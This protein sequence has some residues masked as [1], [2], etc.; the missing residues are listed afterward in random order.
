MASRMS[1]ARI[2]EDMHNRSSDTLVLVSARRSLP[3]ARRLDA[4]LMRS[5]V[6]AICLTALVGCAEIHLESKP[7]AYEVTIEQVRTPCG[8]VHATYVRPI[9]DQH[10]GDL[11]VFSTGDSGW[12]G[13]SAAI[14]QHLADAGYTVAGFSAPEILRPIVRSGQRMST[15]DAARGLNRL[16]AEAKRH[17][18][19]PDST[20]ILIVGF[21]RGASVVAFTAI[22][23]ALKDGVAGAVAIS[24]TREA[25]YLEV[26][27]S[28]RGPAIQVDHRGRLQLY[29][30]L[31]LLGAA[32]LAV[33]QSTHDKYVRADEARR[34]L[35][36][37]TP[38]LR[39]Y[40]VEAKNHGFS[41]A[42][43]ALMRDLDDALGWVHEA[44]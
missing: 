29:P 32:R 42:R 35:G 23:P 1:T 9:Q 18:G 24:L 8:N 16:Y 37:D 28:E 20:P 17:L 12:S 27:E 14:F 44:P 4:M 13:T 5:A 43:D 21:S 19:L 30:T 41:D 38:K 22:H 34:L 36:A 33:I 15:A 39:L 40:E 11:V 31:Q 6:A 2:M 3:R 7:G 10:P 25:D 26:P